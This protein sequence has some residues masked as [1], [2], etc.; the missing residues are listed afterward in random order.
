M[1]DV[2]SCVKINLELSTAV[3]N[4]TRNNVVTV[5]TCFT[6][7]SNCSGSCMNGCFA[8]KATKF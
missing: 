7:F 8:K 4:P 6:K 1:T 2:N 3:E 5:R